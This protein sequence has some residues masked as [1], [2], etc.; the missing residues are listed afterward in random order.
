VL[1][2]NSRSSSRTPNAGPGVYL[3]GNESAQS[4]GFDRRALIGST[5]NVRLLILK[6]LDSGSTN[7]AD[8]ARRLNI[9]VSTLKRR[10]KQEDLS[11]RRL[12]DGVVAEIA[13][14]ALKETR[15]PVTEIAFRAGYAEVSAFDRAFVRITGMTPLQYR[16]RE[17]RKAKSHPAFRSRSSC[18]MK[19]AT[20]CVARQIL[21]F[22]MSDLNNW[23]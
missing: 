3:K 16:A 23:I 19:S 7:A 15:V 14:A 10:L 2:S 21:P 12:R 13:K 22:A 11:Y 4:N 18:L 9:S 8:I 6:S 17:A 1:R 20:Y 5:D